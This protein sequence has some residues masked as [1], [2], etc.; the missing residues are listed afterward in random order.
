MPPKDMTC[1]KIG[2]MT[3]DGFQELAVPSME[4][5]TLGTETVD[6]SELEEYMFHVNP[7]YFE[8]S[9]ETD[10]GQVAEFIKALQPKHGDRLIFEYSCICD[11]TLTYAVELIRKLRKNG[12]INIKIHS[13]IIQNQ[14]CP[15]ES[16]KFIAIGIF[17]N[18][19]NW[20]KMRGVPMTRKGFKDVHIL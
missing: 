2:I 17:W 8:M 10:K 16:T 4:Q 3:E 13:E 1:R 15:C 9:F 5:I 18:T 14:E 11:G 7:G 12:C 20:R 19:N 6:V